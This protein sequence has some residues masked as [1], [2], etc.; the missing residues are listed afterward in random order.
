[1]P[2]PLLESELF[3]YVKGAFTDAK[4]DREGLF[5]RAHGGTLFLDEIGELPL[6]LQ[7]K[8]LR[9]LQERSIRPVGGRD[10]SPFDARV[11]AATNRDLEAAVEDGRF[12]ED[13]FYRINVI[14][15]SVPPLRARG[16]DILLLARH[17]IERYATISGKSVRGI[18]PAA[19]ERMLAYAWPGNVRELQNCIER[20]VT[21]CRFSDLTAEDLPDKVR[22]ARPARMVLDTD[23]LSELVTME[24]VERRYVLRVF[25]VAGQNKSLAAKLLGFN[26]KTLYRKLRRWGAV[27]PDPREDADSSS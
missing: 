5:H 17:F 22:D 18:L 16:N 19:A 10:E 20:A 2:E 23:D 21:L 24:E 8:L 1:M 4:S 14:Q 13:L 26:R 11:V 3:G 12:R 7:P 15:I 27:E 25:E 6:A 9:V